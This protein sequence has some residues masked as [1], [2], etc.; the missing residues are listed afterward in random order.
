MKRNTA[1]DVSH[2]IMDGDEHQTLSSATC[3]THAMLA[4]AKPPFAAPCTDVVAEDYSEELTTDR[5][6]GGTA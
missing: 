1:C 5:R 2:G 4:Q 3:R 6:P